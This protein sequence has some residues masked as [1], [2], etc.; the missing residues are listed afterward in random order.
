M[1]LWQYTLHL[2]LCYIV[3]QYPNYSSSTL[4]LGLGQ[5]TLRTDWAWLEEFCM[6]W[7]AVSQKGKIE[8]QVQEKKQMRF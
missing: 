3:G 6:F 8:G 5:T 2:G 7:C 1:I 4:L